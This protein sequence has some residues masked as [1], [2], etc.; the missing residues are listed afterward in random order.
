M[1]WIDIVIIA[2]LGLFA[3]IGFWKGFFDGI[4]SLCS[5]FVSL[6]ISIKVAN[7]FANLIRK[8]V[9]I[10]GWF[11]TLLE[12]Q[13]H[14]GDSMV[15]FGN[16]YPREKVATFLTVLLCGI[17]IFIFIRCLIALLK[18]LFKSITSKSL[19]LS[20]I[21]RLLGLLLGA[22]KGGVLV[23][24]VL[25]VC[26]I[27]T[28]LGVPGLS[29]VISNNLDNTKVGKF[30][31][32]YVDKFID[33]KIT[34][35]SFEEIIEGLFDEEVAKE[36]DANTT[37]EVVYETGKTAYEFEVG[38]TIDYSKIVVIYKTGNN[39]ETQLV[40][41]TISNFSTPID[42]SKSVTNVKTTISA[43]GKTVEFV[44]SVISKA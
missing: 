27:I 15:V 40:P 26:S 25:S 43:Y 31:F 18:N 21:N 10:D 44:Y 13:F 19:T 36:Q 29:T 24:L 20:G 5:I 1:H 12:N 35:K 11:N 32:T 33:Q 38:E 37:L 9:D 7:P 4:L 34:G 3:L 6:L 42:T 14:V 17:L 8:V 39:T 41:I 2:I 16:S 22:I 23:V 28:S 30:A